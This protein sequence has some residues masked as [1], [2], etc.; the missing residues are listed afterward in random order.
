[1]RTLSLNNFATIIQHLF[2]TLVCSNVVGSEGNV[3]A[4]VNQ[5]STNFPVDNILRDILNKFEEQTSLAWPNF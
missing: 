3:T 2:L 1:M 4:I 5:R